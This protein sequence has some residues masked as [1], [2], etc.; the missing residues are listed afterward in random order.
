ME[1]L[2]NDI[3]DWVKILCVAK[4]IQIGTLKIGGKFSEESTPELER[5][6]NSIN[7]DLNTDKFEYI[8]L[9]KLGNYINKVGIL[10]SNLEDG[11]RAKC[12]ELMRQT[13]E[14]VLMVDSTLLAAYGGYLHKLGNDFEIRNINSYNI[15]DNENL[16]PFIELLKNISSSEDIYKIFNIVYEVYKG[17]SLINEMLLD[18]MITIY[19]YKEII[20]RI[21][22]TDIEA[23]I[24]ICCNRIIL[25]N[26]CLNDKIDKVEVNSS[27]I[28]DLKS[29]I[30][31]INDIINEELPKIKVQVFEYDI[32]EIYKLNIN[33]L[34]EYVDEDAVLD[35]MCETIT[36]ILEEDI[37]D[38]EELENYLS[39][40]E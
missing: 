33:H 26:E 10:G 19:E 29:E 38:V 39:D 40:C 9:Y 28:L 15:M 7:Q 13:I 18:I 24:H 4:S 5:R 21:N 16:K 8:A 2:F 14:M 34:L 3:Y 30:K 23:F 36:E 11:E 27:E 32:V 12:A 31:F 20:R 37:Q 17:L 25:L 35:G 1:E 6:I 22:K